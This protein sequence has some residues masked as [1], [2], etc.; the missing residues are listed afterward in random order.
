LGADLFLD[1]S[2]N[3]ILD[4]HGKVFLNQRLLPSSRDE[5]RLFPGDVV[6]M[7]GEGGSFTKLEISETS[8]HSKSGQDMRQGFCKL[9]NRTFRLYPDREIS[10]GLSD[11]D[12]VAVVSCEG[13]CLYIRAAKERNIV[14]IRR[15]MIAYLVEMHKYLVQPCDELRVGNETGPQ[16]EFSYN[17]ESFENQQPPAKAR[18]DRAGDTLMMP[19]RALELDATTRQRFTDAL[20]KDQLIWT[21]G[22]RTKECAQC[23]KVTSVNL[24]SGLSKCQHCGYAVRRGLEECVVCVNAQTPLSQGMRL[25]RRGKRHDREMYECFSFADNQTYFLEI[26]VPDHRW[27]PREDV[28]R[29][30]SAFMQLDHPSFVRLLNWGNLHHRYKHGDYHL[31][32][33]ED[34]EATPLVSILHENGPLP[35]EVAAEILLHSIDAL[36]IAHKQQ[37]DVVL[38]RFCARQIWIVKEAFD[39]F[40][41][42]L[43][44]LTRD[45]HACSEFVAQGV[46]LIIL[47]RLTISEISA[48]PFWWC[49]LGFP[50]PDSPE[51]EERRRTIWLGNVAGAF[52]ELATGKVLDPAYDQKGIPMGATLP[53]VEQFLREVDWHKEAAS[54]LEEVPG[55]LRTLVKTKT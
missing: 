16:L 8:A 7:Y 37:Q 3:L 11:N 45:Y 4:Y 32:M 27:L 13:G 17:G 50:E 48:D 12:C 36:L 40:S 42:K 1:A 20:V 28:E 30:D 9:Q 35:I 18:S 43:D 51:G 5:Q 23:H 15:G 21:T 33:L 55:F 2:A 44:C 47:G 22:R 6:E 39:V 31:R 26:I 14:F 19:C 10:I 46:G 24:L 34:L 38:D 54:S 41:V 49:S 25:K 29:A 52:Y 53:E